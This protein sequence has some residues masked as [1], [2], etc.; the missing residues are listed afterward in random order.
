VR[1][2]ISAYRRERLDFYGALN[3]ACLNIVAGNESF[4]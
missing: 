1:E 2:K 3:I 4:L